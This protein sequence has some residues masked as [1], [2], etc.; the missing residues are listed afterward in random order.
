[1]GRKVNQSK[2]VT[3]ARWKCWRR[4]EVLYFTNVGGWTGTLIRL[5][6]ISSERF[7]Q[8]SKSVFTVFLQINYTNKSLTETDAKNQAF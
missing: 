5:V 6:K 3:F 2:R 7:Y 8:I 4:R 1:M